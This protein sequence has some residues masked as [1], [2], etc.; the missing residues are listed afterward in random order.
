VNATIGVVT[1]AGSWRGDVWRQGAEEHTGAI[2]SPPASLAEVAAA[3]E[4]IVLTLPDDGLL[5]TLTCLRDTAGPRTVLV[6]TCP[7][8]SLE[9]MRYLVGPGPALLRAVIP[10]GISPGEGHAALAPEPGT[11]PEAVDRAREALAG[12]GPVEL[13]TEGILDAVA[14][15]VL[16]G[17]GFMCT[18][19]EGLEDG[20]VHEGLPREVARSF[21]HQTAL[22]TALLLRDHAGSPADLKDQVA[23]PG[24]TTIA[25]LAT[26]EDAGVRGAFIRAV[27]HSA[28]RVRARHDA[29]RPGVIE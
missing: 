23:S 13:V 18:A 22:A 16:G 3:A 17:A 5:E 12:V 20:A 11:A 15:L 14:G 1:G 6:S 8:V 28:V 2:F 26:L 19:L 29:A 7:V 27:Q 4:V 21:A 9:L 25:A 10:W 24:G